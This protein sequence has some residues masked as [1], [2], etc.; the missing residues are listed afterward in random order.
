MLS[1]YIHIPF[2]VRKCGY[3]GFY[4]TQYSPGSADEFISGIKHEAASYRNDFS[5]RLFTNI[6]VGGGTP[7]VLSPGQFDRIVKIIREHFSIAD[8]AEF[9]V[10]AN[11]NTVT[12]E[13]L[14]R[15]L[16]HGVNRL[17]L[18]V[19][20]FS[21]DALQTLGRL[22]TAEQAADAFRLARC[23]GFGNIGVDLIYGIPGQTADHWEETVDA[24]I[25]LKPEHVSAYGLSFDEGSRFKKEAEAGRITLSDEDL[26][27]AQYENAV[28]K[29]NNAGYGRYEISNFSLPGFECRHNVNYWERGEYLGLGPGAWSFISER[30]YSN[31]ADTTEY[32]RRLSNDRTAV[33]AHE[34]IGPAS[35]AR[36]TVLLRLRTMK[37][38]DLRGFEREYGPDFLLQLERNAVLLRERGLLRVANG[39]M[40]LTDRGILLSDEV[41]A[42]LSV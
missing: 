4:S 7:T 23:A 41:L 15:L 6:Y 22:H 2:C 31:I 35:A 42:R 1:L 28:W 3:C 27:A 13:K 8:D 38:L 9:T 14:S 30:R 5:N 34:N 12:S 16:K 37:G 29:L 18:G 17:S 32:S 20:S 33:D 26:V 19:Q 11:P 36:E 10:E 24:A 21:D 39:R 40:A 25:A